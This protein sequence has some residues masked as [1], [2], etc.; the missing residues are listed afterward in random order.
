MGFGSIISGAI[1]SGRALPTMD[2][3][4]LFDTINKSGAQKELLIKQLPADL[5]PLYD[6]YQASN[7]TTGQE[8]SSATTD[9]GQNLLDKSQ[10]LYDPNNPMV[11]ATLA[12][13][14]TQDYS[15]LPG[16]LTNLKSQLAA[17]GGLG[18][19]GAEKALTSA[20]MA[21]AQ[22]FSQQAMTVQGQQLQQQQQAV[23]AALNKI[24]AMD[25]ATAQSLFGMSKEQAANILQYG[26]QDLQQQLTGLINN[27]DTK[28]N[29]TLGVQGIQAQNAYQN[30]LTRLN[31]KNALTNDIVSTGVNGLSNIDYSSFMSGL[32]GGAGGGGAAFPMAADSGS[33]MAALPAPAGA[34]AM[35][36]AGSSMLPALLA[37]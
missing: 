7:K 33:A 16:T 18:R 1:N 19:G 36:S 34:A 12:A 2:L 29:Q 31:Q 28:T 17:T 26:R 35:S 8:L 5:K 22:Q 6:Q 24:A 20:V 37:L 3:S 14:K 23:Q 10:A 9:I 4:A 27:I 25:D 13:L 21:P 32:G 11:Q 15:T 30:A